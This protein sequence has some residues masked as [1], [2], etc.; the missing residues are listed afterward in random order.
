MA[1]HVVLLRAVNLGGRGK[2]AMAD[3]RGCL[4]GAGFGDVRTVLQ[5]GNVVLRIDGISGAELEA[6]IE[7]RLLERL[8]LRTDVVARMA[9]QWRRIVTGNPFPREAETDPSHLLAMVAKREPTPAAVEALQ[10]A[11]AATGAREAVA[12][13]GGQVYVTFPDG[14]GRSRLTAALIERSLGTAVTGRNWNTV[15]KLAELA[16]R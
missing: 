7:A 10:T 15:L 2:V 1:T 4:V 13:H 9:E 16:D 5:S 8:A 12:V 6:R 11:A 3:L 14:I